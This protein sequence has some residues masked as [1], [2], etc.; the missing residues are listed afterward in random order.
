[1][2]IVL[3]RTTLRADADVAAYEKLNAEMY[4]IVSGMPGFLGADGY[5]SESG[6]EVGI[7]RFE[8]LEALRAWRDHPDHAVTRERGRTE[9]Y[10]SYRVEIYEQVRAYDFTA[11]R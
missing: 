8:T 6:D 1:M 3:I 10:A 9:F 7:V 4:A 2:V 5:K 11:P